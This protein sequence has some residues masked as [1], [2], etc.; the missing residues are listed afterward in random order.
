MKIRSILKILV[1]FVTIACLTY[2]I[3]DKMIPKTNIVTKK[4]EFLSSKLKKIQY[5]AIGDSLTEGVGDSTNQG[6]FVSLLA[7]DLGATY[8]L[9]VNFKNFGVSGNTSQQILNRLK[10]QSEIKK[11]V[12]NSRFVTL[13][14]GGNDILSVLRKDFT[15]IDEEAFKKANDTYIANLKSIIGSVRNEKRDIPIYILGVYNPFYLNFPEIT[16]IQDIIDDWN[17]STDTLT[18]TY[19]SVYFV[20]I[21][22]L[23]Y[24]GIDGKEGVVQTSGD[25]VSVIN[26]ALFSEDHFHPNT[27]G[28]QIMSNAIME[29]L[30]ETKSNWQKK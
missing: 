16:K 12:K 20:P 15:T 27:I 7:Q 1:V 8:N 28:Y 10:S 26:D 19:Q 3:V 23:L 29:K 2:F 11:Q 25:Q 14:V 13:T 5:V 22:Q 6:G 30:N 21:N 17:D 24:K 9:E 4:S 18:K